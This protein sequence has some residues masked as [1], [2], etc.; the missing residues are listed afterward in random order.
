MADKTKAKPKAKNPKADKK[1]IGVDIVSLPKLIPNMLTIM[2]LCAGL[3]SLRFALTEKWELA[4]IAILVAS[5]FDALDGAMARLLKATS[6]LGAELDSL[7]DFLSFGIAPSLI[8][9]LWFTH[10]AKGVGWFAAIVFAVATA[11]RLGRFNVQTKKHDKD[12]KKKKYSHYFEGVPSPAGAFLALCP[13]IVYNYF[14]IGFFPKFDWAAYVI[15][16][17][18]VIVAL[19]MVSKVPTFS[20]KSLKI[21]KKMTIPL[22]AFLGLAIAALITHPWLTLTVIAFLYV[23]SIFFS[24]RSFRKFKKRDNEEFDLF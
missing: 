20:L 12:P 15:S 6:K 9:Y 11:L 22:L 16:A 19:L 4:V 21:P 23:V 10:E 24:F 18:V 3:T 13:I 5:I 7:S 17:W 14:E 1:S 8:V 2:A